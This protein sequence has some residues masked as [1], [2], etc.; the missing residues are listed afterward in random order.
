MTKADMLLIEEYVKKTSMT[1][2]EVKVLRTLI[3]KYIDPS[4]DIC[5]TCPGQIRFTWVRLCEWW[6]LQNKEQYRFIKTKQ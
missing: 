4:C 6:K 5:N 3:R 2:S 1:S